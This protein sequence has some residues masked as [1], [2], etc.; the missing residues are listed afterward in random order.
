MKNVFKNEEKVQKKRYLYGLMG[1]HGVAKTRI[2]HGVGTVSAGMGVGW[3]S[4]THTH[5]VCHPSLDSWHCG[6]YMPVHSCYQELT[7]MFS[8]VENVSP[9]KNWM[10]KNH[11][12]LKLG[13]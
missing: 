5:T 10:M 1:T 7:H 13:E 12:H 11:H 6:E 9:K 4:P 3:T 2:C 8:L